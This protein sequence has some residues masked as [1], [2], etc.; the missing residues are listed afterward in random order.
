MT[1]D[2][3]PTVP[4]GETVP[5]PP[6]WNL[7]ICLGLV[8]FAGHLFLALAATLATFDY[9]GSWAI[10]EHLTPALFLYATCLV[11]PF[12]ALV[13]RPTVR[14]AEL[15]IFLVVFAIWGQAS[16]LMLFAWIRIL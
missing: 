3:P 4:A 5:P 2:F 15:V 11:W 16:M 1:H 9:T 10:S 7:A 6:R 13:L 12:I 14:K 8:L